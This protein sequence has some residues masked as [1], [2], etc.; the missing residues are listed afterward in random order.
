MLYHCLEDI[1]A[2]KVFESPERK[3]RKGIVIFLNED[4]GHY[5]S[6]FYQAGMKMSECLALVEVVKEKI[7]NEMK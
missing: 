5:D 4:E 3:V 1:K 7:L 6:H 2:G